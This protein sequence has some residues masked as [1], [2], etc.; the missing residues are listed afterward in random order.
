M[1]ILKILFLFLLAGAMVIVTSALYFI[2]ASGVR[3]RTFLRLML[4]DPGDDSPS[5]A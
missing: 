2:W 5:N 4:G 1:E 3:L